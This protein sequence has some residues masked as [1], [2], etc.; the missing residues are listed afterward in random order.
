MALDSPVAP[1]TR[2]S[3]RSGSSRA[4][5]SRFGLCSRYSMK[6]RWPQNTKPAVSERSETRAISATAS[7]TSP[8]APPSAFGT[9]ARNN[10][11]AAR[12]GSSAALS[13]VP[14]HRPAAMSSSQASNGPVG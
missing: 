9:P 1:A 7:V 13:A 11:A 4:R 14:A 6:V 5:N 12:R 3:S 10:P 8:P 2:P